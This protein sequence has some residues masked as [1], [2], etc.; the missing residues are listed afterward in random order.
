[1]LLNHLDRHLFC[2]YEELDS[3]LLWMK[4]KTRIWSPLC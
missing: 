4:R 2:T 1:M 3:A